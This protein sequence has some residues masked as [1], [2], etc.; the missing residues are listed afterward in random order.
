MVKMWGKPFTMRFV[1]Y[2]KNVQS[3]RVLSQTG[4]LFLLINP[5]SLINEILQ[6]ANYCK[7]IRIIELHN[8]T[9]KQY[10]VYN[11]N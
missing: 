11:V 8:I 4:F 1:K 10:I 3:E 5:Q 7:V 6:S 9:K 2:Y